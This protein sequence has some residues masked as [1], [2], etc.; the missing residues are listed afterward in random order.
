MEKNQSSLLR[1]GGDDGERLKVKV[2]SDEDIGNLASDIIPKDS[3]SAHAQKEL[4]W[5][6]TL[7]L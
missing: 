7:K 1:V 6:A 3:T 4:S 2:P 5:C